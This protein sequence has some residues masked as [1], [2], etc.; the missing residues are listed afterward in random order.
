MLAELLTK[1]KLGCGRRLLPEWRLDQEK[2]LVGSCKTIVGLD[3]DLPSL[4]DHQNISLK[5]RGSVCALPFGDGCFDLVTA[6]MVVEHLDS[7]EIRF[8]DVLRILKR[9]GLFIFHTPNA[10]SY[11]TIV[12]RLVPETL[13]KKLIYVLE[14]RKEEDVFE[15]H[16]K[17]NTARRISALARL[18]GFEAVKTKMLVTTAAFALV[19]PVAVAELIWIRLLMTRP[20]KPLRT[21]II[22][23]LR[24]Q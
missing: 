3:Y 4:K 17:A 5:V 8:K 23:I 19:L 13:K 2:L 12:N 1:L 6:N 7:P 20:F 14:G 10:V 24:K 22:A 9:G 15:T 18:T 11:V 16:Y 21:N